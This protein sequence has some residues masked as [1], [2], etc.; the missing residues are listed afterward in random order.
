MS[1]RETW[2]ARVGERKREGEKE[3]EREREGR[4]GV[5]KREKEGEG[6]SGQIEWHVNKRDRELY[7]N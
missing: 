5:Q 7:G 3:R 6:S 2:M 1:E 4:E